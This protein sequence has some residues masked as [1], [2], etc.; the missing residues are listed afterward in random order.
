MKK[1]TIFI[2]SIVVFFTSCNVKNNSTISNHKENY[3]Y[4]NNINEDVAKDPFDTIITIDVNKDGIPDYN[5]SIKR[6][7]TDDVPCSGSSKII[8]INSYHSDNY[9]TNGLVYYKDCKGSTPFDSGY[10]IQYNLK[11]PEYWSEFGVDLYSINWGIN[12]GWESQWNGDWAGVSKKY[13]ALKFKINDN[14][15]L[16]WICMS[17]DKNTGKMIIHDYA[18]QPKENENFT[19]GFKP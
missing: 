7:S 10:T 13:I 12:V 3:N 11:D 18:F 4:Y 17:I 16:G 1:I 5:I 6:L 15:H 2:L 8:N 14:Y 9:S 19:T